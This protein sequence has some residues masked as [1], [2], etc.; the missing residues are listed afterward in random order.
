[1][2]RC[3]T[4]Y[5]QVGFDPTWFAQRFKLCSWT[6]MQKWDRLGSINTP[7]LALSGSDSIRSLVAGAD[8][9][10]SRPKPACA[11]SELCLR[12]CGMRGRSLFRDATLRQRGMCSRTNQISYTIRSQIPTHAAQLGGAHAANYS[13]DR[14]RHSF[15]PAC[16]SIAGDRGRVSGSWRIARRFGAPVIPLPTKRADCVTAAAD[17]SH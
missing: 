4:E 17:G 3:V 7:S 14:P 15:S 6:V 16:A 13:P 5:A 9:A 12:L 8:P 1:M 10:A 2:S 11:I